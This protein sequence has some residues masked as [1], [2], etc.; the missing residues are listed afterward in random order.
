MATGWKIISATER[1]GG[2][3]PM[4]EH[5]LVA[6]ADRDTAVKALRERKKLL[7]ADLTVAG[8]ATA[9]LLEWLDVKPGQ[10]LC[11]L[12]VS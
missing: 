5:F 11:V 9:D 7:D 6:I 3:P 4:K 10:I 8:E 1:L 2:G 12:A